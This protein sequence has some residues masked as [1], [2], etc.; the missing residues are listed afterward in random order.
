MKKPVE[1]VDPAVEVA[2]EV[3]NTDEEKAAKKKV[4]A[5]KRTLGQK[6]LRVFVWLSIVALVLSLALVVT[7]LLVVRHYEADLPS[8]TELRTYHPP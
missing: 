2:K 5:K 1:G 3:T 4:A 6:I 8:V 7:F